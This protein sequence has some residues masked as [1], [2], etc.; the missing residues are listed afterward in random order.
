MGSDVY[1][2]N[3][4]LQ[5]LQQELKQLKELAESQSR[6]FAEKSR[7]LEEAEDRCDKLTG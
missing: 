5:K 7:K 4:E 3:D 1:Q 6:A 2:K